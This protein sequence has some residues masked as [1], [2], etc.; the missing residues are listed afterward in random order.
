MQRYSDIFSAVAAARADALRAEHGLTCKAGEALGAAILKVL[1]PEWTTDAPELF[2]NTNGLFFSIWVD[3]ACERERH[4]RYNLHA[5][6]LRHLKGDAFPAREFVRD[7]RLAVRDDLLSWPAIVYP[8]GPIT[9]FEGH[10]RLDANT[11]DADASALIDRFVALTP[12]VN[13]LLAS[14]PMASRTP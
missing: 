12:V 13:R 5:K 9:L 14:A 10:I 7:F 2:L 1:Q 4:V 11:L 8:K 3:A 6:K